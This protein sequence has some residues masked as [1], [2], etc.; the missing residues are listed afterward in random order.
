MT[1]SR[2][3][4]AL[5]SGIALVL[6]TATATA[7]AAAGG[8]AGTGTQVRLTS[9]GCT[10]TADAS[11]TRNDVGHVI[12]SLRRTNGS[13]SVTNGKVVAIDATGKGAS[14]TW[15]LPAGGSN[16]EFRALVTLWTA[17]GEDGTFLEQRPSKTRIRAACLVQAN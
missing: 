15:D 3:T 9:T 11:W 2:A 12:L 17:A 13:S 4:A 8:K 16:G 7:P 10:F 6:A 14:A 5:V 1:G